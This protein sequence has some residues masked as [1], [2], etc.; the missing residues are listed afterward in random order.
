VS[1]SKDDLLKAYQE[2]GVDK[3][4]VIYVSGSLPYLREFEKP[5]TAVLDAHFNALWELIGPEGT[6]VVFTQSTN[7]CNTDTPFDLDNTAS[8]SGIFSEY[9]RRKKGAYRS[10]HPFCSFSAIGKRA[11]EIVLNTTH[12][13]YGPETPMERMINLNTLS[14]SIGIPPRLTASTI[15]HVEMV[16]GVPYRYTKEFVQPVVRNGK[17]SKELFY[18]YVWNQECKLKRDRLVKIFKNFEETY[19]ITSAFVG[20]GEVYSYSMSEFYQCA[21]QLLKNDIYMWLKEEPHIRPYRK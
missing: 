1:Y 14:I 20:K 3:A 19:E 17:I 13:A 12:H 21:V 10:F 2:I 11:K 9:V 8:I 4:K 18:L 16:M 6:I 5:G 15:H 7:L